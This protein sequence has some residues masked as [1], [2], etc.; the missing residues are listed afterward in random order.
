LPKISGMDKRVTFDTS[1]RKF[2][3]INLYIYRK[4]IWNEKWQAQPW[5]NLPIH[6]QM[7]WLTVL[8]EIPFCI[9]E[10]TT[11]WN[12]HRPTGQHEKNLSIQM[13]LQ[14][15]AKMSV[16]NQQIKLLSSKVISQWKIVQPLTFAPK[17]LTTWSS[18]T[19]DL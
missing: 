11:S 16:T 12:V 5:F 18:W 8:W 2:S 7:M 1:C 14:H 13:K 17:N 9:I 6:W 4:I 15:S 19:W 3:K 10:F